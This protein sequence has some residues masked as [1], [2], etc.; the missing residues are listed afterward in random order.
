M[1]PRDLVFSG[2]SLYSKAPCLFP[3]TSVASHI[4]PIV[5]S[6]E[7]SRQAPG[8]VLATV[9]QRRRFSHSLGEFTGFRR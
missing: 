7:P 9:M 2:G 5:P 4:E 8:P 6:E 3:R 1:S